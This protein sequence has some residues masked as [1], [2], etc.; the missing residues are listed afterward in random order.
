MEMP[1]FNEF[2]ASLT[3]ETI[4]QIHSDAK[5]KWEE[6]APAGTG[7]QLIGLS[8][9]IALELLGAYHKWLSCS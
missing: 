3:P 4:L 8:W 5:A 6:L 1:D 9:T 7:D 2:L